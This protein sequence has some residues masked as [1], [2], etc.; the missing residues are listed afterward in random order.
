MNI[1]LC[2][3]WGP[4]MILIRDFVTRENN[5]RIASLV[6]KICINSNQYI[7]LYFFVIHRISNSNNICQKIVLLLY[8]K[9]R[10]IS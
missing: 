6:T 1:D 9:N 7:T 4:S 5:R 2:H 8:C 3:M 10:C